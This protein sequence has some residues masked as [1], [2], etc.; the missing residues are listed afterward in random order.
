M[1]VS[2]AYSPDE[3]R[4]LGAYATLAAIFNGAALAFA[5][6]RR[7]AGKPLPERIPAGD[8][9][10]LSLGTHRLTRLI[11]KDRVTSFLRAP[12]TRYKGKT[13][14][15][16][17][18]EQPRGQGLQRAIG[19]L[20]VCPYCLAHWVGA[21]FVASYLSWPRTTR[22]VATVFAVVGGADFVQQAWSAAQKT[23]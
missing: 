1:S 21:A 13:S 3:A 2:E 11:T 8:V 22:A 4:P 17:V 14:S 23:A 19:E 9:V 15:A 12:F 20:I 6:T 7:R 5:L 16:E 10:L 18:A